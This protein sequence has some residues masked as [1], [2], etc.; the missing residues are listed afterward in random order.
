MKLLISL[1]ALMALTIGCVSDKQLEKKV[2]EL[3][4]KN[5]NILTDAIKENPSEFVGAFQEAVKKA[6]GDLAKKREEAEKKKL[7]AAFEN[8]LKPVIRKDESIRG[9]KGAP[10]VLVEYSDFECPFCTRGFNTVRTLLKK[11]DGKIQFVFKHLPLSFHPNA[12]IASR[13]YEAIRLQD[14]KKA[15]EFHDMVFDQQSKLK[16]GEKF[17]IALSK[18]LGVDMKKLAKDVESETVKKRIDEDMKEAAKFGMQGTPGF[19][20]N[21]IPVK[22]AYPVSHF[23]DIISKLKAKGKLTL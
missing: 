4:K 22:G 15:F 9:T 17:V 11:Y 1:A 8:P 13:Y 19:I 5:P 16:K 6:Q 10:I 21:G 3:L 14:E 23:E 20:I 12:M 18:K 2:T 7:E